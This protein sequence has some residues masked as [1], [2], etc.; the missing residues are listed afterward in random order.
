MH[1]SRFNRR[2]SRLQTRGVSLVE[3]C[4]VM[5]LMG[6]LASS[7]LPSMQSLIATRRIDGM[8]TQLAADI[9]FA[10]SE[11][12]ARNQ[13]IRLSI[14]AGCYVVHTG[15]AADCH[16]ADR[17][18]NQPAA[19]SGNARQIKTVGWAAGD[20]VR[21]QANVRS[22]AFEPMLGTASPTGTLRVVGTQERAVH[23][24][25]N[26][27]GRVRSCSPQAAVSGYRAC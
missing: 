26:L 12:V 25:V 20:A 18:D 8:A 3:S 2:A 15:A 6:I 16:C 21:V 1:K 14:H 4:V 23:Q 24:V 19:C 13:P 11:A 27:M 5:A 9:Q 17:H 22:V 10:R 7:A